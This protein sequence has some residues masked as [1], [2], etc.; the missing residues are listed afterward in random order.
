MA[1]NMAI[2]V[3][4]QDSKAT[5]VGIRDTN[6]EATKADTKEGT[7]AM[8]MEDTKE[9]AAARAPRRHLLLKVQEEMG[10]K[11]AMRLRPWTLV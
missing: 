10:H 6:Q 1:T 8:I 7:R 11:E 3:D 9:Q 4:K 2:K 5:M